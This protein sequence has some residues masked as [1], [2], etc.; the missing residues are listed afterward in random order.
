VE[1]RSDRLRSFS[2]RIQ[3]SAQ[4]AVEDLEDLVVGG[5]GAGLAADEQVA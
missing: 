2:V 1:C 4:P 5:G 3:R